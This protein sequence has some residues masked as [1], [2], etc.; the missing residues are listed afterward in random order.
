MLEPS[1][2]LDQLHFHLLLVQG[3]LQEPRSALVTVHQIPLSVQAFLSVRRAQMGVSQEH[4]F[5]HHLQSRPSLEL[6]YYN[7]AIFQNT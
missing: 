1:N 2:R 6:T 5:V 4:A 3:I 7:L